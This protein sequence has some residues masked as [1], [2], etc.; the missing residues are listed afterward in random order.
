VIA[1]VCK[2]I[3]RTLSATT[4]SSI[5][6]DQ[7]E[8][9]RASADPEPQERDDWQRATTI[10]ALIDVMHAHM[11]WL[12][13][14]LRS[15]DKPHARAEVY[16]RYAVEASQ[17]FGVAAPTPLPECGARITADLQ[18][19]QRLEEAAGKAFRADNSA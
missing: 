19:Y 9:V 5:R 2:S 4:Q 3:V 11:R 14:C 13:R 6:S 8:P 18:W 12:D 15:G 17:R 10:P 7:P 1:F 16:A